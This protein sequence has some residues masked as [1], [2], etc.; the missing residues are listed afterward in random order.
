MPV[1]DHIRSKLSQVPHRPG[2]YI[3]SV[4][5]HAGYLVRLERANAL[6]SIVIR[7]LADGSEHVIA[8]DEQ[9][10]SLDLQRGFEFDTTTLRFAYSSMT[11]PAE[12]WDYDMASRQ[13]TLRK[14]QQIPSGHDPARYVTTRLLARAADGA[15]VPVSLLHRRGLVLDGT[16]PLLLYGYGSYGISIPAGF[17]T[18]ILSLVDRG[19]IYAIAH[20]R[21]GQE[22][23]RRWYKTG[24]LEHKTNTFDDFIAVA[25]D[26]MRRKITSPNHLGIQGGSNGGLLVSTVMVQRPELL[27]AVVCQVPLIDMI[28]YTH[29]GAGASWVAEYGD[30]AI[31]AERDY[32]LTYS[33]YQNVKKGVKYPPVFFVT[34][35]SDDRVTP[36]HARK[37]AAKMEAQGHQVLF[38]ENTDG[39][40]AAAANHTEQAEM[41]ALTFAYFRKML[42]R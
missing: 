23:G 9:A 11:T 22:K 42:V 19:F 2:V 29:I 39:G 26:L 17:N 10:Y 12:T 4:L 1:T 30:P 28:A 40:H 37:M 27:G 15:E 21:G 8:F 14:R 34:A 7:D 6:P 3:V 16:A 41:N 25:E 31:P 20:V 35:T 18:N 13:R 36:V 5:L 32:I 24:R 33:P 38:Y